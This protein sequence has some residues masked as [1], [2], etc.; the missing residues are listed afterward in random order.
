[1]KKEFSKKTTLRQELERINLKASSLQTKN[2]HIAQ[3]EAHLSLTQL[4]NL[5]EKRLC[6]LFQSLHLI[7]HLSYLYKDHVLREVCRL[8]TLNHSDIK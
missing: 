2:K 4:N 5:Q 6:Y 3:S 1:M 7:F 8:E